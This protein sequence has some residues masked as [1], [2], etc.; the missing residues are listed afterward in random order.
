MQEAQAY[1]LWIPCEQVEENER[2]QAVSDQGDL[3]REARVPERN[4]G[5]AG[6]IIRTEKVMSR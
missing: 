6:D 1:V 3:S 4:K 2:T 5:S